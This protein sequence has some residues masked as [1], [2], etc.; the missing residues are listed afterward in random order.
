[1]LDLINDEREREEFKGLALGRNDAPQLHAESAI[2]DCFISHWDTHGLK[3]HMRYTLAGGY[4]SIRTTWWASSY[5]LGPEDGYTRID[6]EQEVRSVF[7]GWMNSESVRPLLLSPRHRQVSIGLAWDDYNYV[8]YS[9]FE[10]DYVIFEQLPA[11]NEDGRFTMSGRVRNGVFLLDDADLVV[12]I[13]YD[14]P[15][16][17][18]SGGQ[19]LRTGCYDSGIN[20][21]AIRR[22]PPDRYYYP[23]AL[24][25]REYTPC[26]DPFDVPVDAPVPKSPEEQRDIRQAVLESPRETVSYELRAITADEWNIK[27]GNF[28]V[29]AGMWDIVKQYGAGVYT[30]RLWSTVGEFWFSTYS[31]FYEVD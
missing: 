20:V 12:Q 10:G 5:C 4:D 15:P 22:K 17:G 28:Q 27:N 7:Q 16:H 31:I 13:F 2:R 11:I 3:P 18:L 29:T 21:A 14:P 6:I 1:M 25:D 26:P 19:L 9:Q 30:V 24:Y 23:F 8:V